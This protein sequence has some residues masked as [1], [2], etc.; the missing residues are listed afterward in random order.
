M[1]DFKTFNLNS[2]MVDMKTFVALSL[3]IIFG[4]SGCAWLGEKAGQASAKIE[5]GTAEMKQGYN[6]GYKG[7]KERNDRSTSGQSAHE[8]A[9]D[10]PTAREAAPGPTE[11]ATETETTTDA[12][13]ECVPPNGSIVPLSNPAPRYPEPARKRDREG[14]VQVEADVDGRGVPTS[15]RV[16]QS[17]GHEILDEAAVAAVGK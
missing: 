5:R 2:T 3:F 12:A 10:S 17:S 8:D 11:G 6:K 14:T 7:E 9:G 1:A 13:L 15:V 16:L 4:F